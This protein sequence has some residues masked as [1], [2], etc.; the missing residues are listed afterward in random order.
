MVNAGSLDLHCPRLPASSG[1]SLVQRREAQ[2]PRL[3]TSE[4][5][6]PGR[7]P[8]IFRKWHSES[9]NPYAMRFITLILLFTLPAHRVHRVVCTR[10][11]P[12]YI[13]INFDQIVAAALARFLHPAASS[14]AIVAILPTRSAHTRCPSTPLSART[15]SP[16]VDSPPTAPATSHP[17]FHSTSPD[18]VAATNAH[19]DHFSRRFIA[20]Q[21]IRLL[22]CTRSTTLGHSE[23]PRGT[24]QTTSACGQCCFTP[25]RTPCSCPSP[26]L[27]SAGI[28]RRAARRRTDSGP[29]V[30]VPHPQDAGLLGIHD[31][32][33]IAVS[34]GRQTHPSPAAA[35]PKFDGA[36]TG[37]QTAL[38]DLLMV[39]QPTPVSWL[40]WRM[41][42]Y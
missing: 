18:Y 34:L 11:I 39:C 19:F 31:H 23:P 20:F 41:G 35:P 38:V 5:G 42:R 25:G 3:Q 7:L 32:G 26:P 22:H 8:L 29:A 40:T 9:L 16:A 13:S 12:A 4:R 24:G 17:V 14:S 1:E 6:F 30:A 15:P 28:A 37:L 21:C 33:G 27:Q 2:V 36:H 10:Q